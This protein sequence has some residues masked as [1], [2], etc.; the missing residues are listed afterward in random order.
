MPSC[1]YF[2][3]MTGRCYFSC[4][5][6]RWAGFGCSDYNPLC[7]FRSFTSFRVACYLSHHGTE[8]LQAQ[9]R[10]LLGLPTSLL[11]LHMSSGALADVLSVLRR[12]HSYWPC[13]ST[14]KDM[15]L[16]LP[17]REKRRKDQTPITNLASEEMGFCA[18][19]HQLLVRFHKSHLS[20]W[21]G[22]SSAAKTFHLCVFKSKSMLP[23]KRKA[24]PSLS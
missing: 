5:G 24:I 20:F 15:R 8:T 17:H 11:A 9:F 2:L 1:F 14:D 6:N 3:Q 21:S 19:F 10:M 23:I 16:S 4:F 7:S 13:K 22:S 18:D 12:S